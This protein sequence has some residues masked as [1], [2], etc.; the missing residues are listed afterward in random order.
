M[1]A[2]VILLAGHGCGTAA[3]AGPQAAAASAAA[4]AVPSPSAPA[5][6]VFAVNSIGLTE[7]AQEMAAKYPA[8]QYQASLINGIPE[9][10]VSQDLS[11]LAEP[12]VVL[13]HGVTGSKDQM[14][15]LLSRVAEQGF[16]AVS[17]DLPGHGERT[18]GPYMFLDV[19]QQGAIDLDQVLGYLSSEGFDL[20][21]YALGGFSA[22]AIETYLYAMEGAYVP[23]ILIP[24]SGILDLG[25]LKESSL[26]DQC[27]EAGAIVDPVK[28]HADVLEQLN[29]MRQAEDPKRLAGAEI[30]ISHGRADTTFDCELAQQ[31]SDQ[32]TAISGTTVSLYLFDTGHVFPDAF[33]QIMLDHLNARLKKG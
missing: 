21:K 9:L 8:L 33:V 28:S 7:E 30:L 26:L 12:I 6:P 13:L 20:S 4:T 31:A 24:V 10:E 23:D 32:L 15:Y 25:S 16:H 17:F 18:D 27:Y 29:Q 5:G 1:A 19:L 14:S 3:A 11:D 22:G 2:A